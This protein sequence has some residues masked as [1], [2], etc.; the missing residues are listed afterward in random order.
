MWNDSVCRLDQGKQCDCQILHLACLQPFLWCICVCGDLLLKSWHGCLTEETLD[1]PIFFH[2]L[3]G[4]CHWC[5]TRYIWNHIANSKCPV[6]IGTIFV[7]RRWHAGHWLHWAC[8]A[9]SLVQQEC[10]PCTLLP[11]FPWINVLVLEW[12]LSLLMSLQV[13]AVTLLSSSL[14]LL[15]CWR[16]GSWD[17]QKVGCIPDEALHWQIS[18][19]ATHH[20]IVLRTAKSS[21]FSG[22]LL[23]SSQGALRRSL[24]CGWSRDQLRPKS[25]LVLFFL[26]FYPHSGSRPCLSLTLHEFPGNQSCM[27]FWALRIFFQD[28]QMKISN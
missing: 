11:S 9:F 19:Q 13:P 4:A 8:L 7:Q 18:C 25:R 23:R 1:V 24:I 21:M 14:L 15:C 6:T 16:R 10:S 22:C 20:S 26:L 3:S 28:F 27:G 17:V 5:F 12:S 2:V